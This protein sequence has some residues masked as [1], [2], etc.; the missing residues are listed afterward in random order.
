ME[1]RSVA[2]AAFEK[3]RLTSYMLVPPS[4]SLI[5]SLLGPQVRPGHHAERLPL[6]PRPSWRPYAHFSVVFFF[7]YSLYYLSFFL[8][9]EGGRA[10]RAG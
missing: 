6:P 10:E 5:F 2:L 1:R 7:F 8:H 4:F 3:L 9:V